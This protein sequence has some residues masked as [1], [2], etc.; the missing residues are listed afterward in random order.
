MGQVDL[1]LNHKVHS[2]LRSKVN[3]LLQ[4]WLLEMVN[5]SLVVRLLTTGC[6]SRMA[7]LQFPIGPIH[8][9]RHQDPCLPVCLQWLHLLNKKIK[10]RKK[11]QLSWLVRREINQVMIMILLSQRR[12]GQNSTKPRTMIPMMIYLPNQ[13]RQLKMT[14]HLNVLKTVLMKPLRMS[15]K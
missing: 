11:A 9:L 6:L 1:S 3:N 12:N 7:G 5:S 8:T 2:F 10:L 4:T 13:H 15:R 14:M